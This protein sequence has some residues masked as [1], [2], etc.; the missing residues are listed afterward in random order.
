MKYA[1]TTPK[2]TDPNMENSCSRTTPI[3]SV[4]TDPSIII[5][6]IHVE[7]EKPI[8]A[9]PSVLFSLHISP[10]FKLTLLL[11]PFQ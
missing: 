7:I 2:S 11:M 6:A 9:Y 5:I 10:E 4:E 8:I 3:A 1:K